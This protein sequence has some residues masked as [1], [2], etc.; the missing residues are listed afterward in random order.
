ML[1]VEQQSVRLLLNTGAEKMFGWGTKLTES[2][3]NLLLEL[4]DEVI[5][6]LHFS[7]L[8]WLGLYVFQASELVKGVIKYP[9]LKLIALLII[10]ERSN[11][12]DHIIKSHFFISYYQKGNR[13]SGLMAEVLSINCF[14]IHFNK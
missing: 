2:C 5:L 1:E 4:S 9:A 12:S 11:V 13:R 6:L 10:S 7:H 8:I 3:F 14:K